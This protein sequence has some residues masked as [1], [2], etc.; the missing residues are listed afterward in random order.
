[1]ADRS[2]RRVVIN[3]L[4]GHKAQHDVVPNS[5]VRAAAA[6]L[7]LSTKQVRRLIR[8]GVSESPPA[9]KITDE[10]LHLY[11]ATG[12]NGAKAVRD[13]A[14]HRIQIPVGERQFRR[15]LSNG[16]V[17]QALVRGAKEGYAGVISAAGY[18]KKYV[19]HKA[20]TYASDASPMCLMVRE[21]K[22]GPV[23]DLWE[24]STIDECTRFALAVSTTIGPPDLSVV[25]A[26]FAAAVGGY[27]ADDGT[28]LGGKP[29]F[30]LTDNGGEFKGMAVT[31]GL[32]R[33]GVIQ[34]VD[35]DSLTEAS[36]TTTPNVDLATG[37][38]LNG[39]PEPGAVL[40]PVG[41]GAP[42]KKIFTNVESPWED[43][44]VERYHQTGQ[45]DFSQD[46]P[47]FVNPRWSTFR[48]LK[49]REYWKANPDQ[50]LLKEQV[51]VMFRRFHMAY[52]FERIHSS[53]HGRTPFQA[54]VADPHVPERPD[55]EALRL[56]MLSETDR[57]VTKGHVKFD[58][59]EYYAPELNAHNGQ[60]VEVRYLPGRLETVEIMLYGRHVGTA[61]REDHL[62][63]ELGALIRNKRDKQVE[64]H[65]AHSAAA[66]RL[67]H[68]R[69]T[70]ELLEQGYSE[71]DL[72]AAPPPSPV[73]TQIPRRPQAPKPTDADQTALQDL[74]DTFEEEEYL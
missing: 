38:L 22:N 41:D 35:R 25:V 60:R 58:H 69:V 40:A 12:A 23:V 53:L 17:D 55:A 18:A 74:I 28:Y 31:S 13:A 11:Y 42:V 37:E 3:A 15:A 21:S 62:T 2:E 6:R 50:L 68:A 20:H 63:A 14:L 46:L 1:M 5:L 29:D 30:V 32:V 36:A 9:F 57:V 4:R 26:N 34:Y 8:D 44:R 64:T 7:D 65:L 73:E 47:G 54:W 67:K 66:D 48:Q 24:T 19:P 10:H 52:N 43:G 27:E 59:H 56:A 70:R 16:Q 71:A 39:E 61:V 49:Q 45:R 72:P 33:V 51:D